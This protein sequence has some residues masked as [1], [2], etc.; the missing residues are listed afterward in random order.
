[1]KGE[2][3]LAYYIKNCEVCCH[4]LL[5][6]VWKHEPDYQTNNPLDSGKPKV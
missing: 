2:L 3:T 4:W 1:M 5:Q 6:G